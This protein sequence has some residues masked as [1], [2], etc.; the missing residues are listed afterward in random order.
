MTAICQALCDMVASEEAFT[1]KFFRVS[2]ENLSAYLAKVFAECSVAYLRILGERLL[3]A[4]NVG[5]IVELQGRLKAISLEEFSFAGQIVESFQE[6][7]DSRIALLVASQCASLQS[8]VGREAPHTQ[9]SMVSR[10]YVGF[11]EEIHLVSSIQVHRHAEK[12]K[13]LQDALEAFYTA[14][15]KLLLDGRSAAIYRIN[16]YDMLA[17]TL[18]VGALCSLPRWPMQRHWHC[19]SAPLP[20]ANSRWSFRGSQV[21]HKLMEREGHSSAGRQPPTMQGSRSS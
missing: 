7:I 2:P 11:I 10:R 19:F 3:I 8:A 13:D 21:L 18:Q 14:S 16:N 15:S 4:A 9:A 12:L 1:E 17:S 5:E 20:I 6:R